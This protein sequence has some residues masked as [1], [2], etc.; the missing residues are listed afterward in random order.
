M[1]GRESFVPTPYAV[2]CPTHG[3][4]YLTEEEYDR[5]LCK[6]ANRWECPRMETDPPG[7]CGLPVEFNDAIIER[8]NG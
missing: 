6:S 3:M 7:Y 5:Q 8:S 1:A 2:Q 4:V